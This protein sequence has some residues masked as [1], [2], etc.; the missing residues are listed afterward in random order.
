MQLGLF[1]SHSRIHGTGR[2]EVYK[3]SSDTVE[4]CKKYIQ[5]RYKLMPYIYG[6]AI[7]CVEKSLPMTRA[8]VIEYQNDPTVWNIGNEFLFGNA[9][10]VAP[11]T[12]KS[13]TREIYLPEGIWTY[14]W[15]NERI[16]GKQWIY[17]DAEI[18]ALP[19]YIR[20]GAL[21]PMGP[22]MNYI[23]EFGIKEIELKISLFER[24]GKSTFVVPVNDESVP[25]EYIAV[26]GK[27]EVKIGKTNVSFKIDALSKDASKINVIR[28]LNNY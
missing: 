5:L 19:L 3:F 8:L 4:I 24:D 23:D 25:V 20:E 28:E 11:I 7:E 12:D 6:S 27:H 13:N 10:L 17:I 18:D 1:H 15:T 2:R 14:W 22:V 26:E 9:L 21:G 16:R